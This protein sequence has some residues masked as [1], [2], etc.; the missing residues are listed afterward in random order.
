MMQF[1]INDCTSADAESF[2]HGFAL[3]LVV[4]SALAAA[5]FSYHAFAHPSK[6][7]NARAAFAVVSFVIM[8]GQYVNCR[9]WYE[10]TIWNL[11][12]TIAQIVVVERL[13]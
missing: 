12:L 3:L 4:L 6:M 1:W 13:K 9:P 11:L 8:C 2:T 5:T 10:V 7:K